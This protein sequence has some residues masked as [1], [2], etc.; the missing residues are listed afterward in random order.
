MKARAAEAAMIGFLA[1]N[2][3]SVC[4]LCES[5]YGIKIWHVAVACVRVDAGEIIAHDEHSR[6]GFLGSS[7]IRN[8]L[9]TNPQVLKCGRATS[10]FENIVLW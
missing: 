9:T 6:D 3:S 2:S 10:I 4:R 5:G 7:L 1:T 8:R